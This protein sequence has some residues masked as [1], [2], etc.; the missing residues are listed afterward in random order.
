[1]RLVH[2]GNNDHM[3]VSLVASPQQRVSASTTSGDQLADEKE[4]NGGTAAQSRTQDAHGDEK[5]SR[6]SESR[7]KATAAGCALLTLARDGVYLPAPRL[8][9]GQAGGLVLSPG[10]R[11]DVAVF[12]ENPGVYR[13]VSSKGGGE[14]SQE[15]PLMEY[16]GKTTDVFEGKKLPA[17]LT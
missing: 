13:F 14:G 15:V 2:G 9:G 16:L 5:A 4:K 7:E 17:A 11:A 12:C 3:H 6:P 10:S 8:L 1:M